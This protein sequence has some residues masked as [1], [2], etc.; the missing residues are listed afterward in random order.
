[1]FGTL[2]LAYSLGGAVKGTDDPWKM[3]ETIVFIATAPI[4]FPCGMVLYG[5]VTAIPL[6]EN[7]PS[8][9]VALYVIPFVLPTLIVSGFVFWMSRR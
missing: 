1:M 6:A 8:L 3:V 4:L 7:N 9:T 2:G 5:C